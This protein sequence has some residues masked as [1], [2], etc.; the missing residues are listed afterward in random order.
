M[1]L[2]PNVAEAVVG[3]LLE[4]FKGGHYADKVI[5]RTL[6]NHAKWGSRDRRF[7]AETV[8]ELVRWWRSYWTLAGLPDEECGTPARISASRMWRVFTVYYWR[9]TGQF[10]G[11]REC[12][13]IHPAE[14]KRNLRAGTAPA[15]R[16]SLPDWLDALGR[17]EFGKDWITVIDALNEPADVFLR[18]NTL[19]T[20]AADLRTR[21]AEE[22]VEC[23]PVAGLPDALRLAERRN[24]FTLRSFREGLFEVQDAG[25][26]QIA[27]L[28]EAAPGMRVVDACAGA[29]GKTLHLAA[30]MQNKGT[31][32]ALDIHQWKLEELRR[33][34]TR[35]GADNIQT[36][37]IEGPTVSRLAGKADRVLLDVP[38]TGLGV[39]RRNPDTKWKLRPEEVARLLTEQAHLLD[40]YSRMTKPGGK[41][42]YATCSILSRENEKQIQT[43]LASHPE[44]RLEHELHL[45]PHREGFD[46]FYAARLARTPESAA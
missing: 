29:G 41:L 32:I 38:C 45:L 34:A 33:R 21:L 31:I 16:V 37:L 42:V 46:G 5:E 27:P 19:R 23:A 44:W 1:K 12:N 14:L 9:Q 8:Y 2:H 40:R 20:T 13:D 7:V 24:V 25:S 15:I 22:G 28:L 10:P 43:F 18:A 36:R 26:Q 17:E 35:A 30:L 4:I 3:S 6:K 39:L 11:L